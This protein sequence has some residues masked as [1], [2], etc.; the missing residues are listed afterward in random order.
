MVQNDNATEPYPGVLE[1]D[2][3]DAEGLELG[4]AWGEMDRG[5]R[6]LAAGVGETAAVCS[7]AP[8]LQQAPPG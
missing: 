2:A 1:E 3:P 8:G 6:P 4:A 5:E 7:G